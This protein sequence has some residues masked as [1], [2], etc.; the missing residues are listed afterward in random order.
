M[1]GGSGSGLLMSD[2]ARITIVLAESHCI[3]REG[4]AA[5]LRAEPE[6]EV[7]GECSDGAEAVQT[8][9]ALRPDFALIDLNTPKLHGIE[10]IRKVR[11]AN[12]PTRIIVLSVSRDEG[13]RAE[14]FRS[15]GN[16]F[17]LK[18]DPARH[19]MD[20]IRYIQ[21][22]GDYITPLIARA[23]VTDR[24]P[25]HASPIALLSRR[26]YEVFALLVDRMRSKD[27]AT[28]MN[29]SPKTVHTYRSSIMRKLG[30][31]DLAGLVKFAIERDLTSTNR[32]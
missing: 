12:C 18:E 1:L 6:L 30:I 8:I 32:D 11:G 25:G 5:L 22:G 4:I 31:H 7:V 26:E 24:P 3:V 10:V 23:L 21:D 15:G 27:I 29:I 2:A 9:T 19:I 17:L 28:V 20:A 13:I 16:G 14:V